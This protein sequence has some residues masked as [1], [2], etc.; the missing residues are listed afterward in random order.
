MLAGSCARSRGCWSLAPRR[1]DAETQVPS[2][3]VAAERAAWFRS[4]AWQVLQ[5][6][7][8]V[9]RC[10]APARDAALPSGTHRRQVLDA[11]HEANRVQDVGLAA[12]IEARDGIEAGVEV[13]EGHALRIRL[14]TVNRDL[15]DVHGCYFCPPL[16]LGRYIKVSAVRGAASLRRCT[17]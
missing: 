16:A 1:A 13:A 10:A 9:V 11:H 4:T 2:S 15:L 3:A 17:A 12:A 8:L 14:E 6:R 7:T 5:T